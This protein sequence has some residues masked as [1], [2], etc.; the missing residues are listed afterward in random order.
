MSALLHAIRPVS[1][2]LFT[3]GRVVQVTELEST[4]NFPAEMEKFQQVLTR[5]PRRKQG[6]QN[7][8]GGDR[9]GGGKEESEE[10]RDTLDRTLWPFHGKDNGDL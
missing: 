2:G 9:R 10:A 1:S 4:A 7:H 8:G 3:A 5:A 6:V